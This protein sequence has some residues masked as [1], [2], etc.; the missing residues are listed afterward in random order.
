VRSGHGRPSF[1]DAPI[2]TVARQ[3]DARF[4]ATFDRDFRQVE[5]LAVVPG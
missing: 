5:G 3:G 2:V 1:A 4:G